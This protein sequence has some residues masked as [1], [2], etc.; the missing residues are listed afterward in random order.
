MNI[1]SPAED[2]K[3]H[4]DAAEDD[5]ATDRDVSRV[6]E[7]TEPSRVVDL[8]PPPERRPPISADH[9][10]E[11][12]RH[13]PDPPSLDEARRDQ[14]GEHDGQGRHPPAGGLMGVIAQARLRSCDRRCTTSR[15][16]RSSRRLQATTSKDDHEPID[17]REPGIETKPASRSTL[18]AGHRP[19]GS[20]TPSSNVQPGV[21]HSERAAVV[22]GDRHRGC[23]SSW[24]PSG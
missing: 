9:E 18:V 1:R 12:A 7:K 22:D 21:R 19:R 4:H 20:R 13:L 6:E 16:G 3:P 11:Q 15:T 5:I 23:T 8:G 14:T 2:L 17:R 10:G 24:K